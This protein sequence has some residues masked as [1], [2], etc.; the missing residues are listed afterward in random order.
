MVKKIS[1][2]PRSQDKCQIP[3]HGTQAFGSRPLPTAGLTLE[4]LPYLWLGH[5]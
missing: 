4:L 1:F 5:S 3:S 2:L